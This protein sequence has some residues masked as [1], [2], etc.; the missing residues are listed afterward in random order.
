[1]FG[2]QPSNALEAERRGYGISLPLPELTADKLYNAVTK[3]LED[4]SYTERAQ[5][6]GT[7]LMDEMTKP[8]DR[9]V[10]WI[11]YALRYPG[12]K[13]MRS[14]VHDLHWTQYFLLDVISF[15][16][17]VVFTVMFI[18]YSVFKFCLRK[19]F[20]FGSKVKKD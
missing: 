6:F 12:M 16:A 9:A 4:P 5:E 14:P 15:L 20:G 8:L 18:V 13:H 7:L 19:I 1:M 17:V 10:W 11:E 2:D 3:V